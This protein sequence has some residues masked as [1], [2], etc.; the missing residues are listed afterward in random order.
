MIHN[1]TQHPRD[2]WSEFTNLNRSHFWP[3]TQGHPDPARID[4][5]FATDNLIAARGKP[6]AINIEDG[7]WEAPGNRTRNPGGLAL[8]SGLIAWARKVHGGPIGIYRIVPQRRYPDQYA[9]KWQHYQWRW[10]NNRTAKLAK[11]LDHIHPSLYWRQDLPIGQFADYATRN[12]REATQYGKP[13]LPYIS[14]YYR[15]AS[16]QTEALIP[17]DDLTA[18]CKT[19][20]DLGTTDAVVFVSRGEPCPDEHAAVFTEFFG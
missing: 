7:P 1:A 2:G 20:H 11:M 3:K 9:A 6:V 12:I 19:L 10:R 5:A 17:I 15:G 8:W 16:S 14:P 13:V 4:W 18:M